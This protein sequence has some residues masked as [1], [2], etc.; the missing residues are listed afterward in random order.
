MRPE[1]ATQNSSLQTQQPAGMKNEQF[2]V[3]APVGSVVEVVLYKAVSILAGIWRHDA[4]TEKA[5]S[6]GC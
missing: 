3:A 6:L 5:T 1:G 4:D 2:V